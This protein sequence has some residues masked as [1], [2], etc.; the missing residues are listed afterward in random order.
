MSY[1]LILE[2]ETGQKNDLC[3]VKKQPHS[4]SNQ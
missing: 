4:E 2:N 1:I 3:V